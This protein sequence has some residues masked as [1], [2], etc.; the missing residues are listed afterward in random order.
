MRLAKYLKP[1]LLLLAAAVVLLLVQADAN[2]QL[3]DYM[4]KIVNVGIQQGGVEEAA[5][6]AVRASEMDRLTLFMTVDDSK[7]VLADYQ[8]V[9]PGSAG[10]GQYR[11]KY[12]VLATEPVY[13]RTTPGNEERNAIDPIMGKAWLVVSFLEQAAADPSKASGAGA[14]LGFDLSKMPKGTDVFALMKLMPPMVRNRLATSI[15]EKFSAM[16]P[17]AIVQAAASPVQAEYQAL[18]VDVARMQTM[19]IVRVGGIMLLLTLI[20]ALTGVLTGLISARV[21]AGVARDLRGAVFQKVEGFSS[22]EFDRFSTASLITRSTND[23][24]QIQMVVLMMVTIIFYAPIIGVWGVFRAIG[25]SHSMWWLIGL[26]VAVLSVVVFSVYKIAVPKFKAMQKLMDR[27]NLVSR[28]S[29]SGM[30]VIRAF[31]MQRHEEK[32][33]DA[34]N[35]DL[36]STMLFINRVM[37]VMMPFMMLIMNGLSLLIIWVGAKQVEASALQVGDLMAFIQYAMQIVFAFLMLSMMFIMIPRAAVSAGRVADVLETDPVIRDPASPKGLPAAFD[38]TVEFRNVSFRYPGGEEDALSGVS[39]TARPGETTAVIGPT[40]AGKSTVVSL[41]PRFYDV[42]GGS[43]IVGGIDVRELTQAELRKKIG[44]VPQKSM[45]FSGTIATNVRYADEAADEA[46]VSGALDI[47]QAA[48]FVAEAPEGVEREISQGGTN[49]SGGQ[50]QRL[51]IARAV[52]RK[53]PIYI[54]DDSFSSLDFKTDADLRRAL[55]RETGG[56]TVL[57]VTQRISTVMHADQ[58]IVL[59][60]GKV[61]GKG[62]HRDLMQS[63]E[64]YREIAMSQLSEEELS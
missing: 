9:A 14:D 5:P 33:F 24:M 41:I 58:I 27:L 57:V 17:T 39:F 23:V 35:Q 43:V 49:V 62:T 32:R 61:V 46:A 3:P 15:G 20:T 56:S 53:P 55:K 34:A 44:Y 8:L 30:M 4:S 31:N 21:S 7:R 54:F 51:S 59:D 13:V 25:K 29:L 38:G 11:S 22:T 50:K 10:A 64:T 37:V 16:G 48:E 42:T 47:A 18:G 36:T 40:G 26:A 6:A 45:L 28:E 63:C 52:V 60:D 2:L 1:Y 12:P 19:Y